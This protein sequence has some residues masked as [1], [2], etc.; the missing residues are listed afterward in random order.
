[1]EEHIFKKVELTGTS[2]ASIEDAVQNAITKA[3]AS[4]HHLRWF[5]MQ[6]LRGHIENGQVVQWQAT[7]K[8][9]FKLDD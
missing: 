4:L 1:M 5:E 2:S 6:D 9:G 8:V 7:I 3:S